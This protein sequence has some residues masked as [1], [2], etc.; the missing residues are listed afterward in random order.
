[1]KKSRTG[2]VCSITDAKTNDTRYEYF[3]KDVDDIVENI[4]RVSRN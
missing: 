1:M 4:L 3:A 2:C